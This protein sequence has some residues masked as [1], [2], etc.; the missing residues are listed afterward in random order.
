VFVE[1]HLLQN[2]APSNLNRDDTGAPKTCTFG[3]FPRARISS[4]SQKRSIREYVRDFALLPNENLAER[5]LLIVNALADRLAAKHDR[6]Q[7][8]EVASQ[9]LSAFKFKT[10]PAK[11]FKTQYLLFLGHT[12]IDALA[13]ACDR[14][15][16]SLPAASATA[17][18]SA[19]A[20]KAAAK[21]GIPS[22]VQKALEAVL[23]GGKAAD[24]AMYGRMLADMPQKNIDAASQVAHAISTHRVSPEFDYF[25]AV[26]DLK[27]KDEDAGAGMIGTVEFNSACYYRYSTIDTDQLQKNLGGDADL[28][29][30]AL[31]AFLTASIMALPDAKQNSFAALNP[32]GFV[33]AVVRDR[34]Q[35]CSLANAFE[36]PIKEN[37]NTTLTGQSVT[38]LA[39]AFADYEQM[40]A[41]YTG[42]VARYACAPA[43][44][45]ALLGLGDADV[46]TGSVDA[47]VQRTV[48]A[49]FAEGVTQ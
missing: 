34:K 32:P 48:A 16:D 33:F 38:A 37:P 31:E 19:K 28:A 7:A 27:K 35:P 20:A 41:G 21:E 39:R 45:D 1:L 29:R 15:W 42:V 6:A 43:Y 9:V 23:D 40:Y 46:K 8:L 25:T 13:A 44:E 14:Y 11:D 26:D 2:F 10:D 49:A 47:L 30:R 36:R 5:T 4:Q 22:E 3:G 18:M 12:E 24:L 17:T